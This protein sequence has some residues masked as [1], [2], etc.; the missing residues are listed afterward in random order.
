VIDP[1]DTRRVL[2]TGAIGQPQRRPAADALR[3]VPHVIHAMTE[4]APMKPG[5]M[6]TKS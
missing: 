4:H 3:R 1:A 6:F 5:A 2:A